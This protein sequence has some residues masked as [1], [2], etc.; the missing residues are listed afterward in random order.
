MRIDLTGLWDIQPLYDDSA[1]NWDPQKIEPKAYI[2]DVYRVPSPFSINKA[3]SITY[4]HEIFSAFEYPL[5][6]NLTSDAWLRKKFNLE[7][8]SQNER[9]FLHFGHLTGRAHI[10]LNDELIKEADDNYQPLDI[11]ITEVI[12]T[13]AKNTLLIRLG[14]SKG[15]SGICQAGWIYSRPNIR[16]SDFKYETYVEEQKVAYK[17]L[18]VNQSSQD[19]SLSLELIVRD[20]K[21]TPLSSCSKKVN[22]GQGDKLVVDMDDSTNAFELWSAENPVLYQAGF[23]LLDENGKKIDEYTQPVCFRKIVDNG[24]EIRVNGKKTHLYG[25]TAEHIHCYAQRPEYLR[26]WFRM[27]KSLGMNC[28][29]LAAGPCDSIVYEIADEL[30]IYCRRTEGDLVL[31]KWGCANPQNTSSLAGN[32]CYRTLWDMHRA[33]GRQAA[34]L[35]ERARINDISS[36]CLK[37]ISVLD[38]PAV[39]EVEIPLALGRL[40]DNHPI[41]A[42]VPPFSSEFTWWHEGQVSWQKG[43]SFDLIK[44]ALAPET[45]FVWQKQNQYFTDA[46]IERTVTIINDTEQEHEYELFLSVT[47]VSAKMVTEHQRKITVG[48]GGRENIHFK[49]TA[50]PFPCRNSFRVLLERD[51]ITLVDKIQQFNVSEPLDQMTE[52]LQINNLKTLGSGALDKWL[53]RRGLKAETVEDLGSLGAEDVLIVQKGAP[54]AVQDDIS[55]LIDFIKSGG[56]ALVLEPESAWEGLKFVDV[57]A[58]HG[59][60]QV[61]RLEEISY[62][63]W[64]EQSYVGDEGK[65]FAAVKACVKPS[66]NGYRSWVDVGS[67]EGELTGLSMSALLER[68]WGGGCLMISTLEITKCLETVPAAEETLEAVLEYLRDYKSLVGR[69]VYLPQGWCD[70]EELAGIFEAS[71]DREGADIIFVDA[72][73]SAAEELGKYRDRAQNGST[74]ILYNLTPENQAASESLTGALSLVHIGNEAQG[75]IHQRHELTEGMSNEELFWMKSGQDEKTPIS[76]GYA[77]GSTTFKPLVTVTPDRAFHMLRNE[78]DNA[79]IMRSRMFAM[80]GH[81]SRA[82]QLMGVTPLGKGQIIICQVNPPSVGEIRSGRFWRILAANLL[83]LR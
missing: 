55:T 61:I 83:A 59:H 46:P 62:A 23:Q 76:N 19:K 35:I 48:P 47:S 44:E 64:G 3:N 54:E 28:L 38:N 66:G 8:K 9:I 41:P 77:F 27:L 36:V 51:G 31:E 6:W 63:W 11:D 25:E 45:A 73:A 12:T 30:G 71:D 60:G 79:A 10:Y 70:N 67:D 72:S 56:R 80:Y 34:L 21:G 69:K 20:I 53:E 15:Q 37:N 57:K 49:F 7:S 52:P 14:D 29:Y 13:E 82:A 75:L 39:P 1:Q 16:I 2:S 33:A 4:I 24:A 81:D 65:D 50:K 32:L 5:D 43:S 74:I 17:V 22:V 40:G 26:C 18:L 68:Q 58:T 78:Y 42:V